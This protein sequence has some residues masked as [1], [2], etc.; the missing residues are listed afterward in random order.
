MR[1]RWPAI[2]AVLLALGAGIFLFVRSG[3]KKAQTPTH[4]VRA[5]KVIVRDELESRDGHFTT[6]VTLD[7][8]GNEFAFHGATNGA[9][10]RTGTVPA[11]VV[12][13]F[14]SAAMAPDGGG[15]ASDK[16]IAVTISGIPDEPG[17]VAISTLAPGLVEPYSELLNAIGVYGWID[18]ARK[19]KGAGPGFV[20]PP[21][22]GP[23]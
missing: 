9:A 11:P 19:S 13:N 2:L 22:L 5:T 3:Q 16:R 20:V 14:L 6:T 12:E 1:S 17:M 8:N 21:D 15:S 4:L 23:H 10:E 7:R 18:E